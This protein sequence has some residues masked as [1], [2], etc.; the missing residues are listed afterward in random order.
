MPLSPRTRCWSIATSPRSPYKLPAVVELLEG[1][2]DRPWDRAAQREY[3][4]QMFASQDY[5]GAGG[6]GSESDFAARD[7]VNRAPRTLG[8]VRLARGKP[9][10]ILPTGDALVQGGAQ[11]DL[12]LRQLLKWQYPSPLHD[13]DDYEELFYIHPFLEVLRLVRDLGS[14]SKVE[15]SLFAVPLIDFEDYDSTRKRILV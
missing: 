3:A 14:L 4:R 12:F 10:I 15:M 7:R 2:T 13:D 5:E 6:A 1:F 8:F 9:P 11:D